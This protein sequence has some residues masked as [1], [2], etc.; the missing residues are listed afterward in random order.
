SLG[1]KPKPRGPSSNPP[2]AMT[3]SYIFAM[4]IAQNSA[5]V[6]LDRAD[7]TCLWHGT[8]TADQAGW[9]TLQSALGRHGATWPDT[10]IIMEATGIYHLAWA[11][12][13]VRAGGEV[14][15]L[16]PLLVARLESFANAL[17]QHKT[18][19]VDVR[20]LAEVARLHADELNRFRY[21]RTPTE[22]ARRQ[23]DHTRG[24][25]RRTLTNVKKALQSHLELVFPALLAAKIAADSVCAAKILQA[26]PT[27]E[28]WLALPELQRRKLAARK[29]E[30]LDLACRQ[31]LADAAVSA[32]CV[33][34]VLTLLATMQSLVANLE[35]C[36]Q[37]TNACQPTA[38]VRLIMSI[39][40]FGERTATVMSTYL[41][42]SFEGWGKKKKITARLQALFGTDPRLRSS[43]K[44]VGKVKMSKRGIC[45][46][47]TAL[48]QASFCSLRKD[49]ENAA[50]Y[51]ALRD[52][53]KE[54]KQALVDV[55]RKQ[56]RRLTAVLVSNQPFVPKTPSNKC[57]AA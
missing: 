4:D 8:V 2:P 50:Y 42:E 17:R 55:M 30:A 11:E 32:A 26:A 52:A 37:R 10:L 20:R 53:G 22:Q 39:P 31:T 14:Y 24:T 51:Q 45:S 44:W 27:A 7:G 9:Q 1:H 23:L 33:P 6:Q 3:K 29:T 34:A 5:V 28:A 46:G 19:H 47:R 15:V 40:G 13:L 38:R 49:P 41:P 43:G 16:N 18:D 56:V 57:L 48:F 54:H 21:R 12:R 36:D 35:D 25:L